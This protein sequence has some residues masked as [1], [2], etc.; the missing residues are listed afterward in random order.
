M[1][2]H[3]EAVAALGGQA[4]KWSRGVARHSYKQDGGRDPKAMARGT[5]G[6]RGRVAGCGLRGMDRPRS[7]VGRRAGRGALGGMRPASASSVAPRAPHP[8]KG[9]EGADG[10]RS[11]G[12]WRAIGRPGTPAIVPQLGPAFSHHFL[13]NDPY[14]IVLGSTA[15]SPS[16]LQCARARTGS[17]SKSTYPSDITGWIFRDIFR[18]RIHIPYSSPSLGTCPANSSEAFPSKFSY[19]RTGP[20]RNPHDLGGMQHTVANQTPR[21]STAQARGYALPV[22]KRTSRRRDER[23]GEGRP[24][25]INFPHNPQPVQA[26][27]P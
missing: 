10:P 1:K 7:G 13:A 22:R 24:T 8:L 23:K 25:H 2:Q 9:V 26:P 3:V 21:P 6:G 17:T 4:W 11:G 20:R 12:A 15:I 19:S 18:Y 16:L 14:H 27:N 5:A